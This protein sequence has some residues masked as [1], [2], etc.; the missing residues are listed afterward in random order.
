MSPRLSFF[1]TLT[2][3]ECNRRGGE[4]VGLAAGGGAETDRKEDR[5]Q[6]WGQEGR[7]EPLV[8]PVN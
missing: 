7:P 8:A 3:G 2:S 4:R 5:G 1:L 6:S